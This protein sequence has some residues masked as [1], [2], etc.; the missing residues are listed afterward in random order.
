METS[1]V[2]HASSPSCKAVISPAS[3]ESLAHY[4]R[5][6]KA[7]EFD[8]LP[9]FVDFDVK[10]QSTEESN[11]LISTSQECVCKLPTLLGSLQLL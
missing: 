6:N 8:D 5:L 9:V 7:V 10:S 11:F 4:Q 2:S 3:K 1:L